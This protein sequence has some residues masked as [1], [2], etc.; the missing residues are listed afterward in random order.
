MK[1]LKILFKVR[2]IGESYPQEFKELVDVELDSTPEEE[3]QQIRE[4][5]W[6]YYIKGN[7]K[8]AQEYPYIKL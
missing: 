3:K 8:V 1:T 2:Y 4:Y 5:Y 6:D 7:Q